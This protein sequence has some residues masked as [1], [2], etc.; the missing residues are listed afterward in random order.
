[1][2]GRREETRLADGLFGA[3]MGYLEDLCQTMPFEEA[4]DCL[5]GNAGNWL[6]SIKDPAVKNAYR[7]FFN[8]GK[9][10]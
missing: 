10:A 7:D 2:F 3:A 5:L 9:V 4:Y 1:M 8:G 6:Q